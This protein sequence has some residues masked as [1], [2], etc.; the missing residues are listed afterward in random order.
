MNVATSPPKQVTFGLLGQPNTGKS[1]IF[2]ALTGSRQHV[3][4]WSEKTVERKDGVFTRRG[5]QYKVV[6]LPDTYSLSANS[7]EEIITRNY[8]MQSEADLV[9]VLVEGCQKVLNVYTVVLCFR[10]ICYCA[11]LRKDIM[12]N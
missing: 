9:F 11:Y 2:N 3:G 6:D 12:E 7:D 5:K 1:T 4:N 8:V 10:L